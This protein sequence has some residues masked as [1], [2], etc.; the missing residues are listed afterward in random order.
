MSQKS[1][2]YS[3]KLTNTNLVR[4][5]A[6]RADDNS[7]IEIGRKPILLLLATTKTTITTTI[8]TTLTTTSTSTS[9]LISISIPES[10]LTSTIY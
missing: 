1:A 8:S 4:V 3:G 6:R 2:T 10:T 5:G 9:T 7:T